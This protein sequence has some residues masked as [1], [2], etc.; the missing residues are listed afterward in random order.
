[1]VHVEIVKARNI[2]VFI[3]CITEDC[4]GIVKVNTF[5]CHMRSLCVKTS[6]LKEKVPKVDIDERSLRLYL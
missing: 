3:M 2:L 4:N 6:I 5:C 1:M